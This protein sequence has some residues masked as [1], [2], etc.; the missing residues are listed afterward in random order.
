MERWAFGVISL[1][2][3]EERFWSLSPKEF[4]Y[5]TKQWEAKQDREAAMFAQLRAD[6][7]NGW[8]PRKSGTPWKADDFGAP[9]MEKWKH[10]R[11]TMTPES[12]QARMIEQFGP[13]GNGWRGAPRKMEIITSLKGKGQPLPK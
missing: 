1:G 4:R 10:P 2:L 3:D 7:H 5:L 6:I 12:L 8:M 11:T 9:R 13:S